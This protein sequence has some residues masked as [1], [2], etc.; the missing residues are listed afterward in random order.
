MPVGIPA[1]SLSVAKLKMDKDRKAA[2]ERKN[3][4]KDRDKEWG[5]YCNVKC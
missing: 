5:R 1:T 3:M 2:L 4:N